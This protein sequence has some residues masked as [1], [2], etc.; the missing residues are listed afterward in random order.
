MGLDPFTATG[1]TYLEGC[2]W[3]TLA[4]VV[5]SCH[6]TPFFTWKRW[7]Q[8]LL[9]TQ[10]LLCAQRLARGRC[11]L[12]ICWNK[13][14]RVLIILMLRR[15]LA[16]ICYTRKYSTRALLRWQVRTEPAVHA[17]FLQLWSRMFHTWLPPGGTGSLTTRDYQTWSHHV[18][19]LHSGGTQRNRASHTSPQSALL[20]VLQK[21]KL[22]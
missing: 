21:P 20:F 14:I 12:Q 17:A 18:A 10:H 15:S 11:S 13:G 9:T 1:L 6:L 22:R 8:P 3:V 4:K 16:F 2:P 19:K 7:C 5:S